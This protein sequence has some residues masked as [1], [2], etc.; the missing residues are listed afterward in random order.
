MPTIQSPGPSSAV[1]IVSPGP[2]G[3]LV[4]GGLTPANT[5]QVST[6]P[7]VQSSGGTSST[8]ETSGDAT[9]NV[10]TGATTTTTQNL[11]VSYPLYSSM[12]TPS[13]SVTN[14]A[15]SVATINGSGVTTY[16]S[17]GTASFTVTVTYNGT[18]FTNQ[19]TFPTSQITGPTNYQFNSFLSTSVAYEM[20]NTFHT[21]LTAAGSPN[22]NGNTNLYSS[23]NY[24]SSYVRNT[25]HWAYGYD[26]T[27]IPAGNSHWGSAKECGVLVTPQHLLQANHVALPVGT[28]MVFVA[29]DNSVQTATI[30]S[31]SGLLSN[32]GDI[33]VATLSA[34]LTSAITPA[35]ILPSSYA[36]HLPNPQYGYPLAYVEWEQHSD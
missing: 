22:P 15:P 21:L 30:A 29:N 3:T 20:C 14:N 25:S 23:Y 36:T 27:C 9:L 16:Q 19:I 31:Q 4:I 13:L 2:S 32:T 5:L 7:N 26:L 28:T 11:L 10:V 17:T 12:G 33:C 34:P 18:P 6:T 8:T 24:G 1:K 35:T